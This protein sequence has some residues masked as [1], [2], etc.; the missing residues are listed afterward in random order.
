MY[1]YLK[2]LLVT[3]KPD[4]VVV[5]IGGCGYYVHTPLT[6]YTK[7]K[8]LGETIHLYTS[9]ILREDSMRLFGFEK[10]EEK[11]LF[12]KLIA[13][14][15]VGPKIALLL[16]SNSDRMNLSDIIATRDSQTLTKIP[17]IGKKTAERIVIELSDKIKSLPTQQSS[18]L[19]QLDAI[20]ALISLGYKEKD[21]EKSVDNAIKKI[22]TDA[23]LS[24]L[25]SL[26]LSTSK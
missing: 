4:H 12:E 8:T 13:I 16:I 11:I 18:S 10:E 9:F 1:A 2:G 15:G 6:L 24:E 17:G 19:M 3:V 22:K 5:D 23:S 7:N 25:I 26:S 14:S 20:A 21:A